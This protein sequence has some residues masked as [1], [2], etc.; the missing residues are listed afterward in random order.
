MSLRSWGRGLGSG[1]WRRMVGGKV[2]KGK[3]KVQLGGLWKTNWKNKTP[4]GNN[5]ESDSLGTE[6]CKFKYFPHPSINVHTQRRCINGR[7]CVVEIYMYDLYIMV[8]IKLF[9]VGCSV[10]VMTYYLWKVLW[11]TFNSLL[12]YNSLHNC[13]LS[14]TGTLSGPL[15]VVISNK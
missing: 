5:S 6:F 3:K 14:K 2:S 1:T 4:S 15:S 11:F 9:R 8:C 10:K 12:N 7:M 13:V